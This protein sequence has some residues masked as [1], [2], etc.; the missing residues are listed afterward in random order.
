MDLKRHFDVWSFLAMAITLV[1]FGAALFTTGFTHDLLIEAGVLM[2]SVKLIHLGYKNS[3]ATH[4]MQQ[5]LDEIHVAVRR[6]GDATGPDRVQ[7]PLES[8]RA[9]SGAAD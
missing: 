5:K 8:D 1:L 9:A 4:T 7:K 2:V 6:I 3:V